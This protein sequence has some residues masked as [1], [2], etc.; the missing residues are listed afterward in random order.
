[1][2]FPLG[3]KVPPQVER[4]GG[5]FAAPK[6]SATTIVRTVTADATAK[7]QRLATARSY[8]RVPRLAP[9]DRHRLPD[10]ARRDLTKAMVP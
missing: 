6:E 9:L 1:M 8:R 2:Q 5:L 3:S 4:M 10:R 7:Y